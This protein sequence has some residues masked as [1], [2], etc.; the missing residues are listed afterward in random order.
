MSSSGAW[1]WL[2]LAAIA[3]VAAN[4][5]LK[6]AASTGSNS[7]QASAAAHSIFYRWGPLGL[8]IGLAG[9]L[10]VFYMMALRTMPVSLAYPI[11]TGS[12]MIG[13]ALFSHV[14]F[15]EALGTLKVLGIG[16]IV[17]GTIM[18]QHS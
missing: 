5:L 13:L 6:M 7:A 16:T 2:L 9:C 12:A 10:L 8:G 14:L 3:N 17:C 1:L 4:L 11:V 18:I 15:G